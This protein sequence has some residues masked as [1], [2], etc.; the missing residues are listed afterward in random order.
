MVYVTNKTTKKRSGFDGFGNPPDYANLESQTREGMGTFLCV[1]CM[2]VWYRFEGV[3]LYG[4]GKFTAIPV[5]VMSLILN[6]VSFTWDDKFE[7]Q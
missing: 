1:I 2:Q 4:L 3:S 6:P 5:S 7:T